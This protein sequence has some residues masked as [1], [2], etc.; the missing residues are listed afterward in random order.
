[1]DKGWERQEVDLLGWNL[2][3]LMEH[4]FHKRA[5]GPPLLV[6]PCGKGKE[7][8]LFKKFLLGSLGCKGLLLRN[9]YSFIL[10]LLNLPE[11]S[12]P[13]PFSHNAEQV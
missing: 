6:F 10:W 4:L 13:P 9:E 5:S 12:P 2:N 1:M 3:E 7:A 11:S 8:C